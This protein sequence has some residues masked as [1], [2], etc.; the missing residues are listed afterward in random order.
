MEYFYG[1]YLISDDK[2]KII[3]GEVKKL[4]STSYWAKDR[5]EEIIKKTIANSHCIGV[6]FEKCQVG[7]ARIVTDYAVYAWI[8]DVII[9][10]EHRGKGLG[11]KIIEFIQNIPEIP[12]TTQMLRTQDAHSLYEKYG[13]KKCECM[14]K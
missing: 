6:Y 8:A 13:F 11:K 2:S 12:K 3:S 5:D 4:L 14:S 9:D 10:K 7:F 1:E